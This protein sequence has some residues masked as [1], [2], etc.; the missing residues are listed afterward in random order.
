M[1]PHFERPQPG[2]PTAV[3]FPALTR[4]RLGSGLDVLVI[5]ALQ[6]KRHP[7]HFSL[8]EALDWI[9]RLAPRCAVLTHMHIPLDYATVM[10]ET[11]D[12]V[13]PSFDGMVIEI[14]YESN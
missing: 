7:S 12:N 13:E 4:D 5:D 6:Y 9:A 11:P 2:A 14:A 1:S 8:Q 10:A 3:R